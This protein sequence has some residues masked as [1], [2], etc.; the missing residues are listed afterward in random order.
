MA[1]AGSIFAPFFV[2]VKLTI[3]YY[4]KIQ[5][6]DFS[7]LEWKLFGYSFSSGIF[8]FQQVELIEKGAK[9]TPFRNKFAKIGSR[10]TPTDNYL[11]SPKISLKEVS[12]AKL[13]V[14]HTVRNPDWSKFHL[15][16][17]KAYDAGNPADTVWKVAD[18]TP[19]R[20]VKK[21]SW[22]DLETQEIDL[23]E[24][25]GEEIV[26]AFRYQSDLERDT[27]WEILSFELIGVGKK[28]TTT[29]Y[30]LKKEGQE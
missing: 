18:I 30:D 10:G 27:V 12:K 16:I 14:K 28:V 17:S 8:P 5:N 13:K 20:K 24:F 26:I 6:A 9:W 15:M 7:D 1:S 2:S 3:D 25:I 23:S 11:V 22:V 19:A 4:A 21:N 29:N